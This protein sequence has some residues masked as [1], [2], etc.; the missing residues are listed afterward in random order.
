MKIE[1]K[2]DFIEVDYFRGLNILYE[3]DFYE[4]ALSVLKI[5]D[6]ARTN[7]NISSRPTIN[8]V[9]KYYSSICGDKFDTEEILR[10]VK[11]HLK[12]DVTG[13][14]TIDFDISSARQVT[15]NYGG[16]LIILKG[17]YVSLMSRSKF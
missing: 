15:Y 4:L 5:M 14:E 7:E 12:N 1:R 11:N 17:K 10:I 9:A 3:N 6:K 16:L 8:G 2:F 13:N